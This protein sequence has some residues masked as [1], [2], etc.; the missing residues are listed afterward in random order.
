MPAILTHDLFGRGV[1]EDVVSLLALRSAGEREAFLLGNQGPDPLFYLVVDP[2][3]HKWSP[4]GNA[5]HKTSGTVVLGAARE[6]ALRLE[7]RERSIARAYVAGLACHWLLDS[8]VHPLVYFWQDGLCSAGVPGL[9]GS[10]ASRVHA[11]IERDYDEM[12]LFSLT[13][14]TVE[15]WRPHERVLAASRTVLAA[16]DKLYFYTALWVFERAIDPRTF[17]IAVR[18]FRVA[19]R[20]FDSPR[21]RKRAAL[22]TVERLVTR[23]PFSLVSS[24]SHR[25][26]AEETSDFDNREHRGW[27]NPFTHEAQTSSFWDLFDDARARVLPLVDALAAP[28]L[29]QDALVQLTGN[30]N[31]EGSPTGLSERPAW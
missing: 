4:L 12:V 3:M 19:Q 5:L 31:F 9:D 10:A 1:L 17:S 25:A 30:L 2:L 23:T 22:S 21:G 8:T 28:D 26:R 6:A 11:E 16:V 14:R 20:L 15:Q 29:S 13:G 27:E 18:D 7:G 24:M